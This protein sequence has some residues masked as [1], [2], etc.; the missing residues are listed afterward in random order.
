MNNFSSKKSYYKIFSFGLGL[1]S[2]ISQVVLLRELVT[3]FY[4]NEIAYAVILG[5]WFF[6]VALGSFWMSS[7]IRKVKNS[8]SWFF[9]I[10]IL[11]F[12]VLPFILIL[13]RVIKPIINIPI[14]SVIGIVPMCG[15]TFILIAPVAI[16][17]GA[18]FVLICH[19]SQANNQD[20]RGS[21]IGDIYFF[22]SLGSAVGGIFFSFI[23]IHFLSSLSILVFLGVMNLS[24]SFFIL[25]KYNF[26]RI[27]YGLVISLSLISVMGGAISKMENFSRVQQWQGFTLLHGEDSIYG[28]IAVTQLGQEYSLFENGLLSFSTKDTLA[29]EGLVHY[30]LLSH[31][32]PQEVLLIGNGLDGS[33]EEL[34]KYRSLK[35]DYVQLDPKVVKLAKQFLPATYTDV[36][37]NSRVNVIY[38]DARSYIKQNVKKYDVIIINLSDPFTAVINRYYTLE[39][40]EEAKQR[41][42]Q[43]GIIALTVSS[44]ENY[45]S[46]ENRAY[47]RSINSTLKS[48]FEDVQSIPGDLNLFLASDTPGLIT[49]NPEELIKRIEERGIRNRYVDRAYLPYKLSQDRLLY[50]DSILK[51]EGTINTDSKPIAY[52]Y[53]IVLWSTHFNKTYKNIIEKFSGIKIGPLLGIPLLIL[54]I[55]KAFFSRRIRYPIIFSI[56]STGFSEIIFQMIVILSFQNLY[57]YA[58][59]RIG[60]I[61][62]SFMLGLAGG[63]LWAQKIINR[64]RD[65]IRSYKLVQLGVSFYPFMLI[66]FY[67]V[68]KMAPPTLFFRHLCSLLYAFLPFLA[69]V[70]GGIQYPLATKILFS[71]SNDTKK[72]VN[73]AGFLYAVDVSG[74][75]LGAILS[76]AIFIPLVGIN[77]MAFFTAALNF[78]VYLWLCLARK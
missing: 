43:R 29:S 23:L 73:I 32:D 78:S 39:F 45:L 67:F 6:W 57:G 51:E 49:R 35:I 25:K 72:Q 30:P 41:L 10:Q 34:L 66:L 15:T 28:N 5:S 64:N 56:F 20:K 42:H 44:S 33:I 76:A 24:L 8:H 60:L 59:Y 26:L 65:L 3:V 7:F 14:G 70:I 77:A 13:I 16:L 50:I 36:L 1:I 62:A 22:E 12:F 47:L 37:N 17:F 18:S 40:F 63:S 11:Q 53:D 74:A 4:G 21:E 75:A 69:G 46:D 38:D 58:Y 27:F 31:P 52:F 48:V 2:T 55:G 54:F 19:L 68:F 71:R 9:L 61:I